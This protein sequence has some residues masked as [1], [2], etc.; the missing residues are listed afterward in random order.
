MSDVYIVGVYMIKF[1]CYPDRTVPGLAAEA[2]LLA[3]DDAGLRID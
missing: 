2:A 1:G 3:L